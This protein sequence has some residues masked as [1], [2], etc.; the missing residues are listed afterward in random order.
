MTLFLEKFVLGPI[1]N[2]T[3]LVIDESTS[4]AAVIDPAAPSEAIRQKI[5]EKNAALELILLTHAHFDHIGGVK[6]LTRD[7][8][9]GSRVALHAADLDLWRSGGGSRDF[10]FEFEP[11]DEP[12]L[13]LKDET[14][15][16]LG[17]IRVDVL[18]TPGHTHGHVTYYLPQHALAFCGDL[19]FYHGIGRTDLA[20]SDEP[21]LYASIHEK[22]L[23]LPDDTILYPG[24]G[25]ATRVGEE[26]ENNPFI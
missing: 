11:G 24:H 13:I 16:F 20:V 22:I 15:L 14:P 6:S 3:Y 8:S 7:L 5:R 19:I 21:A 23:T 12:D 9:N 17:N 4:L 18:H 25:P 2:N 10:G 1:E 26:K